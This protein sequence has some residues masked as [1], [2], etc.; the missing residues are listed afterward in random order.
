[1]MPSS[2]QF[3]Y[4]FCA[5]AGYKISQWMKGVLKTCKDL[6]CSLDPRLTVGIIPGVD[7]PEE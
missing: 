1:M 6:D 5:G 3:I 7:M 2:R 4:S